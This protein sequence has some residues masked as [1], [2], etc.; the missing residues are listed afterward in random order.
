MKYSREFKKFI[1]EMQ[2]GIDVGQKKY[3]DKGLFG[4]SQLEM[5]KEE[6][7]D[8]A[9]YAFLTWLKVDMLQRKIVKK[10]DLKEFTGKQSLNKFGRKQ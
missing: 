7:R 8:L 5:I 2:T 3:G 10:S 6:V 1:K 4:D 9:C